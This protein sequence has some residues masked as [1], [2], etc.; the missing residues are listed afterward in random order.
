MRVFFNFVA[1]GLFL[2]FIIWLLYNGPN[3]R[4][5]ANALL[6]GM[7]ILQLYFLIWGRLLFK[8]FRGDVFTY[9]TIAFGINLWLFI[10]SLAWA[11]YLFYMPLTVFQSISEPPKYFIGY[12][13]ISIFVC[14]VLPLLTSDPI[15]QLPKK[16]DRREYEIPG[17]ETK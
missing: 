9:N 6:F 8:F 5:P 3:L 13:F 16:S 2:P 14:L 4:N 1:L 15:N 11:F 17:E 12:V 10:G 7:V